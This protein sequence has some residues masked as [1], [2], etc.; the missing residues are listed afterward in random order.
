MY[1][2]FGQL[3]SSRANAQYEMIS[4]R[5]LRICLVL[6]QL[7]APVGATK[8]QRML[9]A[10]GDD[11]AGGRSGYMF[12]WEH[13][14]RLKDAGVL[15]QVGRGRFQLAGGEMLAAVF[16]D[17]IARVVS[18]AIPALEALAGLRGAL[19]RRALQ[20]SSGKPEA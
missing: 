14:R 18:E 6:E 19:L 9:Q 8:L 5:V 11:W 4:Q 2:L 12:I 13:L 3:R 1:R 17:G 20:A 16:S 15:V 10:G 7:G